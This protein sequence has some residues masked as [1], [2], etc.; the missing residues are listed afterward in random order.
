MFAKVDD[1]EP[2]A[3]RVGEHQPTGLAERSPG[4][5]EGQEWVGR[6]ERREGGHLVRADAVDRVRVEVLVR[7]EAEEAGQAVEA[8]LAAR[9]VGA[10][11]LSDGGRAGA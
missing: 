1:R 8:R 6:V 9:K 10:K 5:E 2:D 11:D 7:V 3:G 4:E